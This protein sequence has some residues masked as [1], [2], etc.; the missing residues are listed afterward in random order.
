MSLVQ[1]RVKSTA[2]C[3]SSGSLVTNVRQEKVV[4]VFE[5][6]EPLGVTPCVTDWCMVLD[7]YWSMVHVAGSSC[8]AALCGAFP[9]LCESERRNPKLQNLNPTHA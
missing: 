9:A 4:V 3:A 5:H 6:P 2:L 8:V 1:V 7:G